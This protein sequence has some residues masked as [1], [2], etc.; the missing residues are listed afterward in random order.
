MCRHDHTNRLS[1]RY[2]HILIVVS[3]QI[4]PHFK[5]FIGLRLD[6]LRLCVPVF[7]VND[8]NSNKSWFFEFRW[9]LLLQF[10][11]RKNA[12]TR[13]CSLVVRLIDK[14]TDTIVYM[15]LAQLNFFGDAWSR[16]QTSEKRGSVDSDLIKC[17]SIFSLHSLNLWFKV[18]AGLLSLYCALDGQICIKVIL[19]WWYIHIWIITLDLFLLKHAQKVMPLA[20]SDKD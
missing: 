17:D 2:R 19:N 11:C 20:M 4:I 14:F 18:S 3:Y 6:A 16:L 12:A 10:E 9:P 8:V 13:L 15:Y 1:G 5:I 7:C